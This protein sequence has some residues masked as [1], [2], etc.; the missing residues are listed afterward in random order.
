MDLRFKLKWQRCVFC[1][2]ESGK[3]R[4]IGYVT[5]PMAEDAQRALSEIRDYDG[6]KIR[7]LVA[8]K[9]IIVKKKKG[10]LGRS[11]T[12]YLCTTLK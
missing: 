4:G 11:D 12:N 9:K 3:C 8:K 2:I 7:V 1:S 10:E 6:K 5:F